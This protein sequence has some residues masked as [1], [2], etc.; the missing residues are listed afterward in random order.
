M[1][2]TGISTLFLDNDFIRMKRLHQFII[3]DWLLIRIE[4][5]F[6]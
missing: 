2:Y 6:L 5:L 1:K 3:N 4:Y